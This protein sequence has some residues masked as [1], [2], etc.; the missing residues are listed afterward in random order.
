[1][2]NLTHSG[3][4]SPDF[5]KPYVPDMK[6][7]KIGNLLQAMVCKYLPEGDYLKI[8]VIGLQPGENY[9]E[10]VN[11]TGPMSNECEQYTIDEIIKLI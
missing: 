6:S 3:F 1:M 9:H 5:E 7:M 10:K 2:P 4:G 11:E 8:K